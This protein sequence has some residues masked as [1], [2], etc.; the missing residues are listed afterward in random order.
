MIQGQHL[1]IGADEA[2]L[3]PM[4]TMALTQG[5]NESYSHAGSMAIDNAGEDSGIDRIYAPCTVKCSWKDAGASPG[6]NWQTRPLKSMRVL[7]W[8]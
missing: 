8:G 4:K 5:V 2:P 3:F 6:V 1:Y 7:V